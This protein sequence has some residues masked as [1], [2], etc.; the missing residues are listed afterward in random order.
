MDLKSLLGVV[1]AWLRMIIL[2][3]VAAAAIAYLITGTFPSVYVSSAR[4]AVGQTYNA[5]NPNAGQFQTALQLTNVYAEVANS[6]PIYEQMLELLGPDAR[7]AASGDV[8][9]DA[10]DGL[11]I[12][13]VTAS[14]TDP[15]LAAAMANAMAEVLVEQSPAI[16]GTGAATRTFVEQNLESSQ[17]QIEQI[18][19]EIDD[20]V[21]IDNRS[22]AQ[23]QRLE[24][25]ESRL[26][27]LQQSY[28]TLLNFS[29]TAAAN[30]LTIFEPAIAP[31]VPAS[32]RPLFNTAIAAMIGLLVTTALAFTWEK[33]DDTIKDPDDVELAT[34]LPTIGQIPQ[35][36]GDDRRPIFYRLAALLYPRSPT[37]EAFRTLRTNIDFSAV[38]ERVRGIVVT[39]AQAGEGKSVVAAN[40][41]VVFAQG[42]RRTLL[43][44]AD[45][46]R[47]SAHALF[48]TPNDNG[49]TTLL[50]DPR[51]SI[52]ELARPTDEPN[53]R[54]ITTGPVPPNPAELLGSHRMDGIFDRLLDAA[55]VVVFDTPPVTVVTD[56]ALLAVRPI[57]TL[58]V[59]RSGKTREPAIRQGTSALSKVSAR[60]L[61]VVLNA[62][63]ERLAGQSYYG[64]RPTSELVSPNV[65]LPAVENERGVR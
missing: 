62:L 10:S 23:Q 15:E 13:E 41:A 38:D 58:L 52:D 63:P 8:S 26:A 17:R 59:V 60:V 14:S 33:L 4:I 55:D 65:G 34:G 27:N 47:P 53:L 35:M 7:R 20:L 50:L 22:T 42:G 48:K 5:L 43:V 36:P 6:R 37:A 45:M 18:Q 49:L 12:I 39:S 25:L 24:T 1:R 16:S 32:P 2:G 56:A 21:A 64:P 46:R 57:A 19:G 29:T 3:T 9:V 54:V 44:D 51:A 61:G 40:L 31:T 11:P 28:A 30:R